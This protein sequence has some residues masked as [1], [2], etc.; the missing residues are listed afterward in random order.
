MAPRR[1]GASGLLEVGA[2]E[3]GFGALVTFIG[4]LSGVDDLVCLQPGSAGEGFPT[5]AAQGVPAS[6]GV[7]MTIPIL[8]HVEAAAAHVAALQLFPGVPPHV[9]LQVVDGGQR[10]EERGKRTEDRGQMRTQ[11]FILS[12]TSKVL[13]TLTDVRKYV[14]LIFCK[15]WM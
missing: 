3:E 13:F 1:R 10:T 4:L 9:D 15:M 14:C 11:A 12:L 8:E 5:D 2:V 6:V 7:S